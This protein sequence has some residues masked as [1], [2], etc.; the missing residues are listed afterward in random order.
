MRWEWEPSRPRPFE[1]GD[2]CAD[3]GDVA[4]P[5]LAGVERFH[6]AEVECLAGAVEDLQEFVVRGL[7]A[8]WPGIRR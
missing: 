1:A 4:G 5:A 7:G 3:E 6:G 2:H 8:P